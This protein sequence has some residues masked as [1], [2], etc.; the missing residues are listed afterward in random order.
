MSTT[1][2]KFLGRTRGFGGLVR[3]IHV[4]TTTQL[5]APSGGAPLSANKVSAVR[6]YGAGGGWR[7]GVVAGMKPKGRRKALQIL[8]EF[9]THTGTHTITTC[10]N[11]RA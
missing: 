11:Y 9:G 1:R 8:I 4:T 2:S 6:E 3:S 5:P 10:T 7:G